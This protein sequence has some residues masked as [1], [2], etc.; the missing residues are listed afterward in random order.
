MEIQMQQVID[1]YRQKLSDVIHTLTLK[2]LQ[3]EAVEKTLKQEREKNAQLQ[4][5]VDCYRITASRE[6]LADELDDW[7]GSPDGSNN[8]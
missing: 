3:L 7:E 6:N 2:E 4:T 8:T 1:S 5:E